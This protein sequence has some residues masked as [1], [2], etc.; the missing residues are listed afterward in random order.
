MARKLS[1]AFIIALVLFTNN[2]IKTT[3]AETKKESQV[4]V[5]AQVLEQIGYKKT[6]SQI[7]I[8][9]NS[10]KGVWAIEK[11]KNNFGKKIIL[12]EPSLENIVIVPK[13]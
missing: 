4:T 9:T 8:E 7:L 2:Y 11:N 3:K 6:G 10:E 12:E 5:T 1:L 13:I